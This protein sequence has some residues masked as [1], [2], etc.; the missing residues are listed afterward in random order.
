MQLSGSS[1]ALMRNSPLLY[2][3]FSDF[4]HLFHSSASSFTSLKIADYSKNTMHIFDYV[5]YY[6]NERIN[7]QVIFQRFCKMSNGFFL[8][9]IAEEIIQIEHIYYFKNINVLNSNIRKKIII[10]KDKTEV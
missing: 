2:Y 5:E 6:K 1:Q 10:N 4:S 7:N 3:P 9:K 8:L